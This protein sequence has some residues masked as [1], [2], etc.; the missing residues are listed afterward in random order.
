MTITER[1][2]AHVR[3]FDVTL[4]TRVHEQVAMLWMEL[5]SGDDLRKLLHI[6]GFDVYDV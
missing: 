6:D 5:G 4:R 2:V 3:K 1:R